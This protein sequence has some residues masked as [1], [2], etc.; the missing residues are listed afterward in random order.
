MEEAVPG[1]IGECY[2]S[3]SLAGVEPLDDATD[4]W[5]ARRVCVIPPGPVPA[6][7]FA[8]TP[9]RGRK[10]GEPRSVSAPPIG[11]ARPDRP[12][13]ELPSQILDELT[14]ERVARQCL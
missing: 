9:G 3:K 6:V 14:G 1:P 8:R 2:E 10:R 4:R 11:Q 12:G 5:A 13:F 7:P